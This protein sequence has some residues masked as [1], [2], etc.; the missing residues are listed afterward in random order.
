MSRRLGLLIGAMLLLAVGRFFVPAGKEEAA[1][2]ALDRSARRQPL[3][4]PTSSAAPSR[5][6]DPEEDDIP[7]NA[8]AIR[9]PPSTQIAQTP[10]QPVVAIQPAAK[11]ATQVSPAPP[12][13]SPQLFTVIGTYEDSEGPAVFLA[14]P[15]GALLARKDSVLL[16]EYRVTAV[17]PQQISLIQIPS[18]RELRLTIP[19]ASTP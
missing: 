5:S 14:G 10:R 6:I 13:Q 17:S 19:R 7:G 9:H 12:P 18:Q 11:P 16:G 3:P 1:S 15:T 4:W 2:P 8:F